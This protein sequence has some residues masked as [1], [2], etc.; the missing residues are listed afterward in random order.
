MGLA[1]CHE[2]RFRFS[3]FILVLTE[4]SFTPA[5]F[6]YQGT[7]FVDQL[8]T[9]LPGL[10]RGLRLFWCRFFA[11]NA[12]FEPSF[13]RKCIVVCT[14]TAANLYWNTSH[15]FF[16]LNCKQSRGPFCQQLLHVKIFMKNIMYVSLERYREHYQ[17]HISSITHHHH[18]SY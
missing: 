7:F 15:D 10:R 1:Q 18:G 6:S 14:E 11:S 2:I 13:G 12:L 9:F 4:I 8:W 16:L 5:N 3:K 17:F